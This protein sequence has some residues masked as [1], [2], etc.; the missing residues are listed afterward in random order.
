MYVL[1]GRCWIAGTVYLRADAEVDGWGE[2]PLGRDVRRLLYHMRVE[3]LR[4]GVER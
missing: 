1:L 3:A 2:R 4:V